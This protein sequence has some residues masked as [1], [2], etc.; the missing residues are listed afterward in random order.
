M[1]A[2]LTWIAVIVVA[3]M[4]ISAMAQKRETIPGTEQRVGGPA[5]WMVWAWK[6]GSRSG[7]STYNR[8]TDG[9]EMS[10]TVE[11]DQLRIAWFHPRWRYPVGQTIPVTYWVDGLAPRVLNANVEAVDTGGTMLWNV[12]PDSPELFEQFRIGS[13]LHIRVQGGV[14]VNYALT[15]TNAALASLRIC[16]Q[17]YRGTGAPGSTAGAAPSSG[18]PQAGA[19]LPVLTADQRVDAVR[20]AANL[21]TKLPG[22]RLLNEE[23]QKKFAPSIAAL[24]PAVVWQSDNIFGLLHIVPDATEADIQKIAVGTISGIMQACKGE[25]TARVAPDVRSPAVRRVHITCLAPDALVASRTILM[26][27]KG[28]VYYLMAAGVPKEE[29]AVTRAE[30]LLRNALFEVVPQ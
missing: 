18:D 14:S 3:T 10:F 20:L 22:F 30:E 19:V 13:V 23:E 15:S 11:G 27:F 28:G 5:G 16:A 12:L 7:C 9:G 17:Q 25:T 4:P 2:V 29:A 24:K 8:F 21:L 26:P 6:E 1:K